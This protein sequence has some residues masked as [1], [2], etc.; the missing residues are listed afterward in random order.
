M[1]T[2]RYEIEVSQPISDSFKKFKVRNL[3]DLSSTRGFQ[4]S[5]MA[6]NMMSLKLETSDDEVN[7]YE[8]LTI[9]VNRV[10]G[11]ES[12]GRD[13]L[14]EFCVVYEFLSFSPYFTDFTNSSEVR[15]KRDIDIP[16][17]DSARGLFASS[18]SLVAVK[19]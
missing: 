18:V 1:C 3:P 13:H 12:L 5:E 17:T 11:L 16:K 8:P 2:L 4:N 6:R 9:M 14:A 10:L 15:S 19:F 7:S